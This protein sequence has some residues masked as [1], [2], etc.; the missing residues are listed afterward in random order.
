MRLEYVGMDSLQA[1][2]K[3]KLLEGA[4]TYNLKFDKRCVLDKE[5]MVKFGTTIHSAGGLLDCVHIDDWGRTKT[6]SLGGHRYFVSFIDDL[7]RH[8]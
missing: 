5:T 2:V 3:Q 1:F 7:F 4:T 8:C 6:T